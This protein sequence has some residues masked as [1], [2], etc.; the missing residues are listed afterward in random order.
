MYSVW[1]E[2]YESAFKLILSARLDIC[3]QC[4]MNMVDEWHDQKG[5]D[6]VL[7]INDLT[8]EILYTIY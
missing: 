4:A 7:I 6:D 8:G 5:F 1:L 3:K 2:A